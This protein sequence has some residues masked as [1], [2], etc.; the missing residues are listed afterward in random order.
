MQ[1]NVELR[2]QR[3]T[4]KRCIPSAAY[5]LLCIRWLAAIT[6]HGAVSQHNP[7]AVAR[8]LRCSGHGLLV[9]QAEAVIDW[10]RER[11]IEPPA[12]RL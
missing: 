2:V 4:S 9:C 1:K 11:G 3:A 10:L 5:P 12:L 7:A 8:A 6:G